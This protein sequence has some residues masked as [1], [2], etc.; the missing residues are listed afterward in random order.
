MSRPVR[1]EY[2][3][4]IYHVTVRGNARDDIFRDDGDR[5]L[6]YSR[7]EE[8][9]EPVLA[10]V[11]KRDSEKRY[12][13]F[14]EAGVGEDDA[15]FLEAMKLSARSIGSEEFR[16]E[17][18]ERHAAVLKSRQRTED[19]MFRSETTVAVPSAS[20]L[21]GGAKLAG[22]KVDD[23]KDQRRR[24][25]WKGIAALLLVKHTGL[26]RRDV[27]PLVGLN[28]GSAVNYQITQA[29]QILGNDK[30]LCNRMARLEKQWRP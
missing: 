30:D 6:L 13:Q 19:V 17:V 15:E 27:A 1:V 26:T 14:V 16:T 22:V 8:S 2:A 4:A 21:E 5:R 24:W 29:E 12:R 18:D 10:L 3:G 25:P 9:V 23:L 28:G 7:F 11:G 20:V